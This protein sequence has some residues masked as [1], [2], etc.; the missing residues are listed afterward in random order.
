MR[1]IYLLYGYW[2]LAGGLLGLGLLSLVTGGWPFL[3]GFA[4]MAVLGRLFHLSIH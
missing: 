3:L 4:G 2:V 1:R